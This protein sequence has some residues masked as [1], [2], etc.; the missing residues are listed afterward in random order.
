MI[1]RLPY[2]FKGDLIEIK[3]RN[4]N[5]IIKKLKYLYIYNKLFHFFLENIE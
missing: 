5:K 4:I 3:Y 2:T 1:L